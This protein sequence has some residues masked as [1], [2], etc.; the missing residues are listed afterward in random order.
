MRKV[1]IVDDNKNYIDDLEMQISF[2]Y[3]N[4]T[5]LFVES[6][7]KALA[8]KLKEIEPDELVINASTYKR[9]SINN[10]NIPIILYARTK[11]DEEIMK[12]SDLPS[13]GKINYTEEIVENIE[14]NKKKY[15]SKK[16]H[17]NTKEKTDD[18][19]YA[20]DNAKDRFKNEKPQED[21]RQYYRHRSEQRADEQDYR[22]PDVFEDE[23]GYDK[24]KRED[25]Y[26]TKYNNYHKENHN[27]YDDGY[28]EAYQSHRT[29]EQR[30]SYAN[31]SSEQ[32][33]E[34]RRENESMA[35]NIRKRDTE[36][37]ATNSRLEKK[38]QEQQAREQLDKDTG[39]TK[40]KAH[41]VTVYS[42]KGGVG[43]TTISCELGTYLSLI[44]H[45]R[46]KFRVCIAD[47][48][49]DFGDVLTALALDENGNTMK[50]WAIDIKEM[51]AE[52]HSP[53]NITFT[54]AQI[55]SYL[56]RNE[57][58]GLYALLA[59]VTNIDSMDITDVEIEIMLNNLINYG[60]FDFII[61]DTGNNTRDSSFIAIEKADDILLVLTQDVNAANCN[62]RAL[63][64]L[65]AADFDNFDNIRLVINKIQPDKL[66]G[67]SVEELE[68]Y[69]KNPVS[70]ER[71]EVFAKI[72]DSNEI[73]MAGYKA[74]PAVYNPYS[75]FTKAIGAIASLLIGDDF[76]LE[77]PKKKKFSLFKRK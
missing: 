64:T 51:L 30:R 33:D 55:E 36:R 38:L 61:C 37:Q 42:A 68:K 28:E 1:L 4:E 70:D 58:N 63:D 41:V 7:L 49:I 66:V 18:N 75:E 62:I 9:I 43:K 15:P 29:E 19:R 60:G 13:Y 10:L 22:K 17:S 69:V 44:N 5:E 47:F 77:P 14:K 34:M 2:S 45:G 35:R 65:E 73:K 40:K 12:E 74:D 31:I 67:L 46:D 25:P 27:E 16:A 20:E 57:K 52:G 21:D 48:N 3:L 6:D 24:D 32:F 56:Q 8:D 50:E 26:V 72:K 53:E 11:R 54:Q 23:Y 76:V 59:P 71:F 39:K